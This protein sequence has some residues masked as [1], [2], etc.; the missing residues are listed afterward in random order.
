MDRHRMHCDDSVKAEKRRLLESLNLPDYSVD[1]DDRSD[2]AYNPPFH[3]KRSRLHSDG[4]NSIDDAMDHSGELIDQTGSGIVC[5]LPET[6]NWWNPL[7][8]KVLDLM[9]FFLRWSDPS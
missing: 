4:D 9:D 7:L 6:L 3:S 1:N 8:H 2:F 5:M